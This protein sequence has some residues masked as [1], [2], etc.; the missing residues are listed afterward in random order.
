VV[1]RVLIIVA[2]GAVT[3]AVAAFFLHPRYAAATWAPNLGD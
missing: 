1:R 3:L 2:L